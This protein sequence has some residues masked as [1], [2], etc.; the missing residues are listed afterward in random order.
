MDMSCPYCGR[1]VDG[2]MG[3]LMI[4]DNGAAIPAHHECYELSGE[5]LINIGGDD[6]Q[7][8]S[9]DDLQGVEA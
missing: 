5:E 7:S 8:S 4:I 6:E 2:S 9:G 1:L 3:A